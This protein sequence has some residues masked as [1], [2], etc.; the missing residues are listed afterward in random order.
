MVGVGDDPDGP[1]GSKLPD[2]V[3][4]VCPPVPVDTVG[5]PSGFG[6]GGLRL[7]LVE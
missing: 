7:V 1:G 2:I 4:E 6:G 5:P 3:I